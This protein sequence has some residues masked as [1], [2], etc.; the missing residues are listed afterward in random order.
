MSAIPAGRVTA[1]MHDTIDLDGAV[2]FWTEMLGLDVLYRADNYAYLSRLS[3]D[4]PMLAFQLVPEPRPGKN[5]LHLDVR[6]DDRSAFRARVEELGG[7]YVDEVR[8]GDFP[9]WTVMADPQGNE[10][11]IYEAQ[12]EGAS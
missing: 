12:A 11:C 2:S 3:E 6:V 9:P 8:E 10:F 4:G 7:S 1:V 5:R